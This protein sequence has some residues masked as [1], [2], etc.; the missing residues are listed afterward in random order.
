MVTLPRVDW[1]ISLH[2]ERCGFDNRFRFS[3]LGQGPQLETPEPPTARQCAN[4]FCRTM[5]RFY[6]LTAIAKRTAFPVHPPHVPG[7]TCGAGKV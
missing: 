4:R 5:L 6:P 1:E 2:C 3:T 7:F